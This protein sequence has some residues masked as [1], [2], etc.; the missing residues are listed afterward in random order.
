MATPS[1]QP[2][3]EL[4][5]QTANAF[6]RSAALKGA[7]DL[8]LFTAIAEGAGTTAEIAN[9]CKASERGVR[10]LCDF[11][12]IQGFLQKRGKRYELTPDSSLF[13]S[14]RSPA[15]LGSAI[16]FLNSSY[17]LEAYKDVAA[18]VRKGGSVLPE[19]GSL[20]PEHPMWVEFARSM[21]PLMFPAAEA[22]AKILKPEL[23]GK[24]RKRVLDVAAGHGIFGVT[25]AKHYSNV[26]ISALDWPNVLEVA[27]ETARKFGVSDR[28]KTL[29]GSAFDVN[30]GD[31]FDVVLL[32]NFLHHFDVPTCEKLLRK[33]QAALKKGGT[34][35]IL[36]FV[37]E[38]DRVSPPMAA[39]FS[40][41]MLNS[42]PSGDAYTMQEFESM[43]RNGGY[44]GPK[45]HPIEAGIEN[46]ITAKRA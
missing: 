23:E 44:S 1:A 42:T 15:F 2:S 30:P 29:P 4:F 40:F 13:L 14:R 17:S 36:E 41:I 43:L 21:M 33:F 10:I 46:V 37:P 12:T 32:T 6:Q 31:G 34:V 20:A 5:F 18:S 3:P 26:E 11:L 24:E 7:I 19:S 45:R 8:D 9:K 22:I 39:A 16:N 25:L 27:K 35:A 38:E 28:Y